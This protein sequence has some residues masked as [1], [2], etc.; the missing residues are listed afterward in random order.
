MIAQVIDG[1][2]FLPGNWVNF[3]SVAI[4]ISDGPGNRLHLP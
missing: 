3:E 2:L 4:H 1:T